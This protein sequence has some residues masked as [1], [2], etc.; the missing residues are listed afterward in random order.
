MF[1]LQP[2]ALKIQTFDNSKGG[3][4]FFK[5]IG[6]PLVLP[7]ITKL[8]QQ[9]Q[10]A[11]SL[12]IFDPHGFMQSF[13][14]IYDCSRLPL[15]EVFVQ[16]WEDLSHET[17]GKSPKPVTELINFTGDI[18]LIAAFDVERLLAS[19]QHL[20]P[21]SIAVLS[22]DNFRLADEMLT[23]PKNYL[24]PLN[25]ATNF[26]FFRDQAGLHTRLVSA[27]Y[28]SAYSQGKPIKIW[29]HLW[30]EQG[31]NLIS[32]TEN[33][34]HPNQSIVVDSK[35]IRQRFGLKDFVGQL[36]MHVIGAAGHDIVKYALDIYSDNNNVLS[37]THDANS[38][39]ADFYA[40]LPAPQA[41]EKVFLWIQNSHP[42]SIPAR[43]VGLTLMGS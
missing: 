36:F 5:A 39:P 29:F 35:D 33:Y 37:C 11:N 7:K 10:S 9:L 34:A 1:E 23:Q 17:L 40:G 4:T 16:K 30:D 6:H 8:L 38:W 12:A 19:I 21:A 14:E 15:D 32:W 28:W 41:H 27:N 24:S 13:A 42:C 22:F 26:V 43:G 18:L 2:N 31:H 20:I 3:T 25:F